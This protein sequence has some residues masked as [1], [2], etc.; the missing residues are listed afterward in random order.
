MPAVLL[1]ILVLLLLVAA[2]RAVA[3]ADPKALVG[4]AKV[5][6][7]AAIV[8]SI[9]L[10]A[11]GL[12]A[13][14]VPLGILGVGLLVLVPRRPAQPHS[15]VSKVRSAF[16]EMELD[17]DSGRVSGRIVSGAR[18]G[19]SL[20][21]LDVAALVSLME[22]FD[23]D[24]QALVASY[25]DRR[26]PAWREHAQADATAGQPRTSAGPMTEKE[27]YEILGLEPGASPED[28]GRAHRDLMKKFHPDHRGTPRLAA[29]I[30]EAKDVL[31][32]GHRRYS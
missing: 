27:A 13:V 29:L 22:G 5:T 28:I 16:V 24:S 30:N 7:A 12:L 11:R 3:K 9:L 14:A 26:H 8:G 19:A 17:H 2:L 18:A 25:L 31:L 23:T 6:S 10:A 32:R 20:D 21:D 4:T 15:R 1:G